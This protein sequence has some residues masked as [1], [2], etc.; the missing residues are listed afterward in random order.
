MVKKNT[1]KVRG[2]D[3]IQFSGP[4][5]KQILNSRIAKQKYKPKKKNETSKEKVW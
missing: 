3:L 4:L 2:G 1:N 5:D